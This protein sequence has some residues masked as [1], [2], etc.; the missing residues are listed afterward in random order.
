MSIDIE[1]R[2]PTLAN[3]TGGLSGPAI[4]P[5]ALRMVYEVARELRLSYPHVPIVGIGGI[6]NARD[7][8]EFIMAGASA[9]QI[10]TINF[11]NP[12]AG[13]EILEGIEEFLSREGVGDIGEIVGAAL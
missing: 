9:I 12:R 3:G 4:K 13:V 2:R 11:V 10:G 8:L 5:I 6:T 7:A 1:M